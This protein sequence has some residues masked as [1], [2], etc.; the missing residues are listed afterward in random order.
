M[1][2]LL[3]RDER[4]LGGCPCV[5]I[6]MFLR[7]RQGRFSKTVPLG[8]LMRG[9]KRREKKR[10][11]KE[12][13]RDDFV[14]KARGGNKRF[15]PQDADPHGV[16]RRPRAIFLRVRPSRA[17]AGSMW[18]GGGGAERTGVP[19]DPERCRFEDLSVFLSDAESRMGTLGFRLASPMRRK[20]KSLPAFP[21]AGA[22]RA[23]KE[24]RIR[25]PCVA[26]AKRKTKVVGAGR[27][28][29]RRLFRK[30]TG[31]IPRCRTTYLVK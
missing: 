12:E 22:G 11:E 6:G 1:F 10:R 3:L 18:L 30:A 24:R 13:G 28:F 2:F 5:E 29:R 9:K 25:R 8:A 20:R 23:G 19:A 31:V 15:Q 27:F 17:R 16:R 7:R 14:R 4:R 26:G 21:F